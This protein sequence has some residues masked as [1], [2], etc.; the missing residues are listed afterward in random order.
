[1]RAAGG[2]V[3]RRRGDTVEVLL[4]HRPRYDDWTLPKG[5]V[6]PGETDEQAARREVLEE[7]GLQVE[8]IRLAAAITSITMNGGTSLRAEGVISRRAI[9][10]II[11]HSPFGKRTLP[12]PLPPHSAANPAARIEATGHVAKGTDLGDSEIPS[13]ARG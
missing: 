7:T 13:G 8:S 4:V 10:S 5:K 1:M 6:D 9:S 11:H 2:V 12:A 3:V